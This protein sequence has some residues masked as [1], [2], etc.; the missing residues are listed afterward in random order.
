[1]IRLVGVIA[2]VVLL[3]HS[4]DALACS[5]M[6]NIR[7]ARTACLALSAVVE[8]IESNDSL[9]DDLRDLNS[10][11]SNNVALL[12]ETEP[13]QSSNSNKPRPSMTV[14][15]GR[16]ALITASSGDL[17]VKSTES[18]SSLKQESP[19]SMSTL[20][21]SPGRGA[22]VTSV[23]TGVSIEDRMIP[24]Q[25][26]TETNKLP[27]QLVKALVDRN[28]KN[29]VGAVGKVISSIRRVAPAT[30]SYET[31]QKPSPADW[32][33]NIQSAASDMLTEDETRQQSE[34]SGLSSTNLLPRPNT[35]LLCESPYTSSGIFNH[36]ITIR[37]IAPNSLDDKFIANLRLSV[38][39]NYNEERQNLFRY[40]SIEVLHRRRRRGAVALIAEM[41]HEDFKRVKSHNEIHTRIASGHKY[42]AK[43]VQHDR[44]QNIIIGSVECS[45]HEFDR[46]RLQSARPKNSLL[47]VT[48]V[49]VFPEARRCGVGRMLL[50]G[51]E[52][53]AALRGCESIYLHVDVT[54]HAAISM[55]E[56]T[57]YQVLDKKRPIYAQFT[58]TLNLHDGALMGRCHNLMCKHLTEETTW[59]L[60]SDR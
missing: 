8:K 53:V 29:G 59:I 18:D 22:N 49:A 45:Q 9:L 3:A 51:V 4:T 11:Q 50:K 23:S 58:A 54:N 56:K 44:S 34:T 36:H 40:K 6:T 27:L 37:S 13:E 39:S 5:S 41:P 1:M 46:T 55:Y 14:A 35:I 2:V 28:K 17:L 43:M 7:A 47:Y 31:K 26:E 19:Q 12:G 10:S 33:S 60:G 30:C 15:A 32:K 38:F 42:N 25:T 16:G 57:G 20:T 48:E 21:V 24:K 52:E